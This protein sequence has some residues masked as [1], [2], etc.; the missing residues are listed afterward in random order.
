M[1]QLETIKEILMR[2]D[3]MTESEALS[4]IQEAREELFYRLEQGDP[5]DDVDF[6]KDWFSLEPDYIIDLIAEE[7]SNI[8]ISDGAEV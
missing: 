5:V 3:S 7:M 8:D 6:M 4:L 2:R 1:E